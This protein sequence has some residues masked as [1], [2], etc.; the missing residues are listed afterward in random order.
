M[1][2]FIKFKKMRKSPG[3]ILFMLS[4]SEFVIVLHWIIDSIVQKASPNNFITS[5]GLYC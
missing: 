1:Y 2:T 3:D 5:N 4:L